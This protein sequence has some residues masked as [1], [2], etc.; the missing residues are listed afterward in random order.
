[1]AVEHFS[2]VETGENVVFVR[3][4]SQQFC[5]LCENKSGCGLQLLSRALRDGKESFSLPL[6]VNFQGT[7]HPGDEVMLT[8][9]NRRLIGLSLR[10]YFYPIV[11][12]VVATAFA[13]TLT[14]RFDLNEAVVIFAAFATL[15]VGLIGV[16]FIS[17]SLLTNAEIM[18][19]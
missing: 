15:A 4:S 18:K 5:Q 10:Q 14:I 17:G 8:I 2:V 7:L 1:M 16:R 13:E 3:T 9:D 6:P 12:A 11:G 19:K